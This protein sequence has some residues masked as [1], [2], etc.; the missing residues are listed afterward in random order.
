MF[1]IISS[2]MAQDA[3]KATPNPFMSFIPFVF[4]FVVFYF[5]VIRPQ[6]KK[7]DEEKKM[8][9]TLAKGDEVFTKSGI[10]GVIHGLTEN[11]VTLEIANGVQMKVLR[12]QIGG[13]SRPILEG[14]KGN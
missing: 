6:K 8:L 4:I 7:M 1:E 12:G 5:L 13:L 9:E 14:K 11:I 10:L 3:A 2:A